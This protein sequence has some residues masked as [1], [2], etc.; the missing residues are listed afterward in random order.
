MGSQVGRGVWCETYW[1]PE[2]DLVELGDGATVNQGSVVQTHLFHDRMLGTDMVTPRSAARPSARTRSSCPA[3]TIGRHATVGPVSL[4]MRG[5]SVPDKT[6]WIGN[7]I[8]P[9]RPTRTAGVTRASPPPTRYLPG[10]GDPSYSV[11]HYDLDLDV[12]LAGNRLAGDATLHVVVARADRAGSCS[13]WRTSRSP[14]CASTGAALR[15]YQRR[16]ERLVIDL[17]RGGWRRTRADGRRPLPRPPPAAGRRHHGDAGW[18]ELTDG[19]IVAGAA[20]R[21]A[22][23]V[24]VQRPAGRQGVVPDRDPRRRRLHRGRQRQA[25]RAPPA[26][27]QRDVGA[28]SRPSRCP[29]TS[30][31]SRSGATATGRRRARRSPTCRC[32]S[33]RPA[34][35]DPAAFARGV[36]PP[37]QMLEVFTRLFGPY[38]FAGYTVVVT[39]DDLEIPLESQTPVDVRAQLRPRRLGRHAADR[40]RAGPPVVRQLGD[41][42]A[43]AA[44]SGCTRG[45]PATASGCG[46]RSPARQPAARP[47]RACTGSG[48]PTLDQDLFLA[49]PGPDLMFDDRVGSELRTSARRPGRS[50][51]SGRRCRSAW[52]GRSSAPCPGPARA[53]GPASRGC[54][55]S[56]T[57]P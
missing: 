27:Q 35:L 15:Q 53:T 51:A 50:R 10:H 5:E 1:L 18:E 44:T 17:A 11:G 7:P 45:S 46:R 6:V 28:T 16:A 55:R 3:A 40:A 34:D 43:L 36:R 14:R 24:P 25:G 32:G 13:T 39:A 4:V 8:G 26:R 30:R 20:A 31:R 37:A 12:Q 57:G 33:S 22:D 48:S 2:A 42:G 19:V 38:P 49:D 52:G 56:R 9:W 41:A 47:R 21:V 29:R 54:G 23:L